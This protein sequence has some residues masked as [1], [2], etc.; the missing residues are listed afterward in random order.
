MGEGLSPLLLARKTWKGN[1]TPRNVGASS[2]WR[3]AREQIL[4]QP[5][6]RNAALPTPRF[7]SRVVHAG[8][9]TDGAGKFGAMC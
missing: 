1:Q 2:A 8:F 5:P 7:E 9:L 6:E 3:K 4:L